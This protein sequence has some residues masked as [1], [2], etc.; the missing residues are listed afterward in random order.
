MVT[1]PAPL[2]Q[3]VEQEVGMEV[4]P[5]IGNDASDVTT[6]LLRRDSLEA[7]ENADGVPTS[8]VEEQ[9]TNDIHR[10][11]ERQCELSADNAE[12][13][14]K[15]SATDQQP[16]NEDHD[17]DKNQDKCIQPV[18]TSTTTDD[19]FHDDQQRS[20]FSTDSDESDDNN[21]TKGMG[22]KRAHSSD[23]SARS[24]APNKR[25]LLEE[26]VTCNCDKN[27]DAPV[28]PGQTTLRECSILHVKCRCNFIFATKGA[29]PAHCP[30]CAQLVPRIHHDV[31]L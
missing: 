26:C 14:L 4:Q 10:S 20:I 30:K 22:P 11:A 29:G 7:A 15:D 9:S 28:Y 16:A 19:V 25:E 12:I 5:I 8:H 23:S 3:E 2:T 24:T 18:S 13:L 6:T 27:V 21:E 17:V 31:T 1:N